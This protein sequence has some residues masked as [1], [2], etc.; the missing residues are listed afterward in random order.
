MGV[1]LYKELNVLFKLAL[2]RRYLFIWFFIICV[3]ELS[4]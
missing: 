1:Y 3:I 4:K 2:L